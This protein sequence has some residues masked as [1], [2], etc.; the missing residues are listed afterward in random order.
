MGTVKKEESSSPGMV[1]GWQA[2]GLAGWMGDMGE[3]G[4]AQAI[5]LLGI[6]NKWNLCVKKIVKLEG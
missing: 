1:V 6:A 3:L 4:S 2:G 5:L